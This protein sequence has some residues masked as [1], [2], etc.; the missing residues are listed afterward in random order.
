MAEIQGSTYRTL[1]Q[2]GEYGNQAVAVLTDILAAAQIADIIKLG[3]LP[4]GAKI[5]RVTLQNA[6]LG[7]GTTLD[8]GYR[9]LTGTDGADD[10]TAFVAAQAT[11]SAGVNDLGTGV[12]DIAIGDGVEVV[13]TVG[14]GAATGQVD[15]VVEY[16]HTG[17]P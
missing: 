2:A 16:V 6:A 9:Y 4:G 12:V 5:L 8:V 11:A 13:A 14:G 17:K 15:V 7:A 1:Q 3:V 10:T